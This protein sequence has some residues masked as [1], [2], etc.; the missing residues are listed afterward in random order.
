MMDKRKLSDYIALVK[1]K[2]ETI[3]NLG[4]YNGSLTG[5]FAQ[6]G[7]CEPAEGFRAAPRYIKGCAMVALKRMTIAESRVNELEAELSDLKE[8]RTTL[9][10]KSYRESWLD[11]VEEIANQGD[12]AGKYREKVEEISDIIC[13]GAPVMWA[14]VEVMSEAAE[15][16]GSLK[17]WVDKQALK[18]E[19]QQ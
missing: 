7:V 13:E 11:A 5:V 19:S 15:W 9:G 10:G 3:A 6:H 2:S 4:A 1:E 18:G 17:D 8:E 14:R 12:L 16:E